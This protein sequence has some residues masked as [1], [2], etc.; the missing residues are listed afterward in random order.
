MEHIKAHNLARLDDPATS[1]AAAKRVGEFGTDFCTVIL[2]ELRKGEGTYEELA[3][4]TGLRPDQVWRRLPDL[5]K[6]GRA[7]AT[8]EERRGSAGRSQRVWRAA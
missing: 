3:Y 6:L 5:E 4:R 2:A 7:F 1:K 8:G